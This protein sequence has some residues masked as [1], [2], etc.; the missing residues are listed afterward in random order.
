MRLAET[1]IVSQRFAAAPPPPM[2]S[3]FYRRSPRLSEPFTRGR[4]SA[5]PTVLLASYRMLFFPDEHASI[6]Q[7]AW[8]D[9]ALHAEAPLS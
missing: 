4:T 3:Q 1:G 8:R 7:M 6:N 5:I 9:F 2:C